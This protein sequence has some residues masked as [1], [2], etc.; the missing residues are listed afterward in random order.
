MLF[1]F[2]WFVFIKNDISIT[3]NTDGPGSFVLTLS[4]SVTVGE[5]ITVPKIEDP[6]EEMVDIYHT[7][8]I[9]SLQCLFDKYKTRFG[10]KESDVLYINWMDRGGVP[11]EAL[12]CGS[13]C[14][15][16]SHAPPFPT[17]SPLSNLGAWFGL[18]LDCEHHTWVH[19]LKKPLLC[20]S[21]HTCTHTHRN[22][23]THKL[24]SFSGN[25]GFENRHLSLPLTP[26]Q[27]ASVKCAFFSIHWHFSVKASSLDC[28]QSVQRGGK[29]H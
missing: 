17:L 13:I 29:V 8:Y 18:S 14:R 25:G 2:K 11:V 28:V 24:C 27:T 9:K 6:T 4:C 10:L 22:A 20:V 21:L 23:H 7:M 19:L 12:N 1:S 15:P 5:P 26:A 3:F 16:S